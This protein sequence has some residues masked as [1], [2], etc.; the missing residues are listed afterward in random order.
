MQAGGGR[1]HGP[2][3]FDRVQSQATCAPQ[4]EAPRSRLLPL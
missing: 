4:R 1:Q 2:E 3:V